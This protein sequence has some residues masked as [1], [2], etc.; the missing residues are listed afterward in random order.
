MDTE[1][2][3]L[4]VTAVILLRR[5]RKRRFKK[6][7]ESHGFA[8]YLKGGRGYFFTTSAEVS[9]SLKLHLFVFPMFINFFQMM[10]C[11]FKN[12]QYF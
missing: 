10:D 6:N 8:L 7:L 4:T 3:A 2:F 5:V 1:D 9:S 11:Y 12:F